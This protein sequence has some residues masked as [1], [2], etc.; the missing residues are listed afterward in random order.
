MGRVKPQQLVELPC[1][2]QGGL[3]RPSIQATVDV[4]LISPTRGSQPWQADTQRR[5]CSVNI[6]K[7][8]NEPGDDGRGIS[9][10]PVSGPHAYL[11]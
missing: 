3:E 6:W 2:G 11:S 1:W 10:A 8:I 5:Q 9:G 7:R 4:S